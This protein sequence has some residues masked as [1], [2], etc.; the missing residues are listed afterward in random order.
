ME[1]GGMFARRS[2]HII[3]TP[4]ALALVFWYFCFWL[5]TILCLAF[6][7][8]F[9]VFFRD[10][11]RRRGKGI[12]AVAD[13]TVRDVIVHNGRVSISTFMNLHNVHVNRAP[14]KA[15]VIA[16]KRRKGGYWPAFHGKADKNSCLI[17]KLKTKIG[18]V[19]ITQIAGTFAWRIVPY[20]R[21]GQIIKKG[22]RIG[23]IR[24]G[25]RVDL[26]LPTERVNCLVKSGD[27]LL[28]GKVKVAEVVNEV[29]E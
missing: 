18:M 26:E 11:K 10:P 12:V 27:K 22:Q 21:K 6:F 1:W 5:F 23:I 15:R 28:A 9:L 20:I 4:L 8:L 14:M 7:V 25:S 29:V 16:I 13:G 17:I 19:R 2:G 24:F 3:A